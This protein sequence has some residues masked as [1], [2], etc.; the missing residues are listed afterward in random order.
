[1][2]VAVTD[3]KRQTKY[4]L[5]RKQYNEMFRKQR[6]C[7]AICG[8][9]QSEFKKALAVDHNH[10]T[11]KNRGLLCSACNVAIGLLKEDREVLRKAMLYLQI[12]NQ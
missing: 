10:S 1:M 2:I 12:Y 8:V 4:G 5:S 6:G 11:G 3:S 9:H 7:C